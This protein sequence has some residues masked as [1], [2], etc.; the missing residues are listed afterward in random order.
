MFSPIFALFRERD[1]AI[2][3]AGN[4]ISLTG[5]WIQRLTIAWLVWD[6]TRSPFWVGVA[7]LTDLGATMVAAL[8]GGV[9]ADRVDRLRFLLIFQLVSA[10]LTLGL[11]GAYVTGHVS[12][13]VVMAARFLISAV[14]ALT[15]PARMVLLS[16]MVGTRN[17]AAAVS[18]G[19]VVFNLAK[20]LGPAIAGVLI[21]LGGFGV[22]LVA[23]SFTYLAMALA[24]IL[25]RARRPTPALRHGAAG[26]FLSQIRGGYRHAAE[27]AG[28]RRVFL[29]YGV[30]VATTRGLEDML[31]AI[32]DLVFSS[33]VAAVATLTALLGL[34]SIAGGLIASTRPVQGLTRVMLLSGAAYAT[35]VG[36]FILAPT[37]SVAGL[38]A[39][40]TGFFAVQFGTAGQ[41]LLQTSVAPEFRGRVM[42]LWY[43]MMK[44][45]PAVGTFLVGTL[46]GAIGLAPAVLLGAS[47]SVG[48]VFAF[49]PGRR[50]LARALEN[51]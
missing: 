17:T 11:A 15:Q 47:L 7:A 39:V 3:V 33:G 44:G 36:A 31:P 13:P 46:A 1:Y 18:F 40:C 2:Y 34:G 42:G 9:L 30:F 29:L 4:A 49:W 19:A 22:A 26:E 5:T 6:L 37:L 28:Y 48:A 23:N 27:H 20:A 25:L 38:L 43:I 41:A 35:C 32:V 16:E 51:P 50:K 12:L 8:L 14:V 21:T 24:V 10:G 45:G